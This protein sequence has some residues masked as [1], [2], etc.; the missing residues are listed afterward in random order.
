MHRLN[1][2]KDIREWIDGCALPA[3]FTYILFKKE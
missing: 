1:K 2:E 3:F